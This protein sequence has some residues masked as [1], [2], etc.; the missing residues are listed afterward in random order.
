[1]SSP[2][3]LTR[4]LFRLPLLLS[5]VA[6]LS[7]CL[8][9]A[10]GD[11]LKDSSAGTADFTESAKN[12]FF[13]KEIRPLLIEHCFKCHDS[14]KSKAGL[15]LDSR[16]FILKGG[17]SG[18]A[19]KPGEPQS[20]GLIQA[21]QGTN[22]E[23]KMPPK[24]ETELSPEQIQKLELWVRLG[25]PFPGGAPAPQTL[26]EARKFWSFQPLN[27]EASKATKTSQPEGFSAEIDRQVR[28][29][30]AAQ[31]LPHSPPADKQ[32]LL[33]RVS[34]DLTGLPPSPADAEQ[35]LSDSSPEAYARLVD[36]LLASPQYGV[37]WARHW[38]DVARYGDTRWVGAGEDRRFPFAYTYR[39][40]VVGAFNEDMAYDRF[41]TLQLA[42]DQTPSARQGDLA[43][44]GFLTV[45][46]WFAGAIPD[47]IDDQ[48]DVITR[49]LLGLTV[50]C[51]RCHDHKFD[52]VSARDYYA[53]YGL[54]NASRMPVD[55]SGTLA[56]LPLL[57]TPPVADSLETEHTALRKRFEDFLKEKQEALRQ[58]FGAP[59]MQAAHLLAATACL[60]NKDDA[61]RA[62]ARERG[63]NEHIFLRWV[64]L[65][66][67][68]SKT[69][70]PVFGAFHALAALTEEEF[71]SKAPE[72]LETQRAQSK[73][74]KKVLEALVPA[75]ASLAETAK[76]YAGLLHK[77]DG[78]ETLSHFEEEAL[79]QVARNNES[80]FFL[81]FPEVAQ[82]LG[83]EDKLHLSDLRRQWLEILAPLPEAADQ[84]LT[85]QT[86]ARQ[87]I[88]EIETFLD[89]RTAA[90]QAEIQ[91]GEKIA[92]YLLAAREVAVAES[93]DIALKNVA[94]QRKL[95]EKMLR[96]WVS[97]LSQKALEN[98]PVF[99]V[100]KALAALPEQDFQRAAAVISAQA[101]QS[102]PLVLRKFETPPPTLKEAA[103][104]Y[105]ELLSGALAKAPTPDAASEEIRRICAQE[106]SPMMLKQTEVPEYFG[107]K[108]TDELLNKERKLA[109]IY[110]ETPGAPAR[111]MTLRENRPGYAQKTFV[112]GNPNVLGEESHGGF[113]EVLAGASPSKF[114]AGRGRAELARAILEQA[115]PLAA[116]V[117]VN[118]LWQWH[119][120]TGLVATT[121][122][123][124]TRGEMPSHPEL[125]DS[126]A[127][128][129]IASGWSIKQL[130]RDILHSATYQQSSADSPVCRTTD[131]ENRLLWRM[132][133]RRL[134][135]EEL[136]DSF[137][138]SAGRLD[139]QLG[140]R[141]SDLSHGLSRRRTLYGAV[142]RVAMPAFFRYFDF[143][144][145]DAHAP[146]RLET[147]IPQQALYLMNN[148][149]V[150]EQ[151]AA[152]SQRSRD[153]LEQSPAR[154]IQAVFQLALGRR[155]TPEEL[156]LALAYIA[157]A[158]GEDGGEPIPPAQSWAYGW[159]ALSPDEGRVVEFV[160]LAY[161]TNN[162][163]R[164]GS[165]EN[166]PVLGRLS[167]N[168]R[169]G[170]AGR[171]NT[172]AAI[173]RWTAPESG[174]LAVSGTFSV[175][176][177]ALVPSGEGVRARIL[178]SRHGSLGSWVAHGTEATTM[179]S[180]I[181]VERGDTL[182]FIT[183]TR[184]REQQTAGYLWAPVLSLK[185][186]ASS[187][188]PPKEMRWDAAKDF[189]GGTPR[190]LFM[191]AWERFSQILLESNEFMFID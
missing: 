68:T 144:G 175:Q 79:R 169:G 143:P 102:N 105:G 180:E 135:F 36:R 136:R 138:L 69:Q 58:E 22:P 167:F 122:D 25:L 181:V 191:G 23:L 88:K 17:D 93:Q 10:N 46:R 174:T 14:A 131:P 52:P 30:L 75:P 50:Q 92:E 96:R 158:S 137:L 115:Q 124:G 13:E 82:T 103:A 91:S 67:R 70:H 94:K 32:T 128:R 152:L 87:S 90:L 24:G 97:F 162:Q 182:D 178:S 66:Q 170:T 188:V 5:G 74:N 80:P 184:G 44:L 83:P 53:L 35:F 134:G 1:M 71:S 116:R 130:H 153:A 163:W 121:S 81:P 47:V 146:A 187:E 21:V 106:G 7:T 62:F 43:A 2:P 129:F 114:H 113:L 142:D 8:Q 110:Q 37:H 141:P 64:R 63:F 95:S 72:V 16:P 112:R 168:A 6:L 26:E 185:P 173:R 166:D 164:G 100:W 15:R 11:S 107:K 61:N 133:R 49:G 40:W 48:I 108:D 19:A 154:R 132:N 31:G 33:R 57:E 123:F 56:S 177:N 147:A 28:R 190:P 98:D 38:L 109:R 155:P 39:D 3:R 59:E 27:H 29:K 149:F 150:L 126:L 183:T 111:A 99:A 12:E 76:R 189:K 77:F 160:P 4:L 89:T 42:A 84:Y 140:G 78:P 51:A 159:G 20:S 54:L 73:N 85:Y 165:T 145:A 161:F 41:V 104:W 186:S 179:V 34:Y 119:F 18:P 127:A 157:S 9:A 86:E 139:L 55:G 172:Q 151:A 117:L 120:G 148:S 176:A 60:G 101:V 171:D 45:G 125:L 118:R 156:S 65:L